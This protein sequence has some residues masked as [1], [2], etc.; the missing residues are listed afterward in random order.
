MDINTD[1]L[2]ALIMNYNLWIII[3]AVLYAF[4]L[5]VYFFPTPLSGFYFAEGYEPQLTHR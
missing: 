5:Y 2:A 3:L 4:S 1:A